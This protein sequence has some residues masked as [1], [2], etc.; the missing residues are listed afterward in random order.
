MQLQQWIN[1]M[2]CYKL[3][4]NLTT[5]YGAAVLSDSM[6]YFWLQEFGRGWTQVVDLHRKAKAK[7]GR[8]S[9]LEDGNVSFLEQ[10]LPPATKSIL[11]F[12]H[13]G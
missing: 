12:D 3:G 11:Q 9:A 1:I 5:C 13:N 8:S 2:F 10:A 6:I 7:S 4:Y